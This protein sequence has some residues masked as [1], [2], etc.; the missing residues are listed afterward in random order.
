MSENTVEVKFELIDKMSKDLEK[1]RKELDK[2]SE[3]T[4]KA[5]KEGGVFGSL[6]SKINPAT[7]A[8][9]VGFAGLTASL[10]FCVT[11]F[12]E[13][14]KVGKQLDAVLKSTN[15]SAG[16]TRGALDELAKSLS[17]MAA[18][19]DEAITR[20]E[21]LLLTFTNIGQT[22]FPQA[23]EAALDM[24]AA[25][26]QDLQ[27]SL[28]QLGKALNDPIEGVAALQRVGVKLTDTQKGQVAQFV[29]MNDVASAQKV[30]LKELAREFGGQAKAQ[31]DTLSGAIDR[32]KT[33]V[34]NA[35]EGFGQKLAPAIQFATNKM[36]DFIGQSQNTKKEIENLQAINE[37]VRKEQEKSGTN[38]SYNFLGA[39]GMD[40][41]K[42]NTITPPSPNTFKPP[43]TNSANSTIV[44]NSSS[45]KIS[46]L[47]SKTFGEMSGFDVGFNADGDMSDWK[48]KQDERRKIAEDES[49]F[50]KNQHAEWVKQQLEAIALE[51]QRAETERQYALSRI[52]SG[53]ELIGSIARVNS[54]MKG[55][56]KTTQGLML[57]QAGMNVYSGISAIW[58]N[59][60]PLIT[61]PQRV[62]ESAIVGTNALDQVYGIAKQKFTRGALEGPVKGPKTGDRVPIMANGG[63][64]IFTEEQQARLFRMATGKERGS[65]FTINVTAGNGVDTKTIVKTLDNLARDGYFNDSYFLKRAMTRN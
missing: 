32:L 50:Q 35:A 16:M 62:V 21:A 41:L 12:M 49:A 24:S 53:S 20:G 51:D 65:G 40:A 14:E 15:S 13:S 26:G 34:G 23:M 17:D 29:K 3:S 11:S 59:P 25:L 56:V 54:A 36:I 44:N 43:P 5:T 64:G 60:N 39:K 47:N 42:K 9:G 18:V 61:F 45:G 30:I 55:S 31:A 57:A 2:T 6:L 52:N 46:Q 4:N 1:I 63:E 38:I 33:A 48:D 7:I 27:S 10:K 28:M 8:A 19:D 58:G 37:K 22:V